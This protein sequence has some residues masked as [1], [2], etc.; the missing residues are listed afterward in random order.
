MPLRHSGRCNGL[1]FS[2]AGSSPVRRDFSFRILE[3]GPHSLIINR[4]HLPNPERKCPESRRPNCGIVG[5][6]N[7][8]D[9]RVGFVLN[10]SNCINN[11]NV[12]AF[13]DKSS[14]C[15]LF[16]AS[17]KPSRTLVTTITNSI[18]KG[19]I[20]GDESYGIG[21]Q[22]SHASNI[23]SMG[24]VTGNKRFPLFAQS[25]K[26]PFLYVL[27]K[28]CPKCI[29]ATVFKQKEQDYYTVD[30]NKRVDKELNYRAM[31]QQFGVMWS[32]K[33]ELTR[34]IHVNVGKPVNRMLVVEDSLPV[35]TFRNMITKFGGIKT[36]HVVN[37][38]EE[39]EIDD[40]QLFQFDSQ[41]A[42]CHK[43]VSQHEFEG[44]AFVEY[45]SQLNEAI[46]RIPEKFLNG[47]YSIRDTLI[48]SVVYHGNT[49]IKADT[50]ITIDALCKN[51]NVS[52]CSTTKTCIWM[53]KCLEKGVFI[54]VVVVCGSSLLIC[55]GVGIFIFASRLRKRKQQY[56]YSLMDSDLFKTND[57]Y[58]TL[59]ISVRGLEMELKLTEEIG[60]GSFGKV[61]KAQAQDDE[62][63]FA[64]KIQ[65]RGVKEGIMESQKEAMMMEQLDTQFVV[66]VY[67]CVCTERSMAIAMEFFPLGSLQVVLQE[68]KLP[69]NARIPML[70]DIAKAME[71]LHGMAIIHRDLKPGNVLVCSVD[72]NVHPMSKFVYFLLDVNIVRIPNE[73]KN[74]QNLG[75]W[76]SKRNGINGTKHD[77]D[78]W[79]WN[80]V[81]HGTRNGCKSQTLH[82]FCGCFQFWYNGCSSNGWSSCL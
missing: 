62:T 82:W 27:N 12:T 76:R 77:H 19:A 36:L 10:V 55:V 53:V 38:S 6:I 64:V 78:K 72:P 40:S 51:M 30:G 5:F 3:F 80:T 39:K 57:G 70:L 63:V 54:P 37:K 7:P 59:S 17:N 18:N 23:V 66:A 4:V 20:Q 8:K 25:T 2:A 69:S 81:L 49:I 41:I 9:E 15:G 71:Y 52:E 45:Q 61:W 79:C 67:G 68:E 65:S 46:P 43:V 1:P 31:E 56:G 58:T 73:T 29:N 35:K 16:F 34:G 60:Q 74:I 75:F 11:G 42:L 44:T 24:M 14:V 32:N 13:A 50:N 33:L 22:V 21:G 47:A 28:V 48:N 26:N